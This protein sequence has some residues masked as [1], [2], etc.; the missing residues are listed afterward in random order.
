MTVL[1]PATNGRLKGRKKKPKR[2]R[3]DLRELRQ[4]LIT[5]AEKRTSTISTFF[6]LMFTINFSWSKEME[7]KYL[8]SSDAYMSNSYISK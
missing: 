8:R 7:K 3:R 6:F 4:K 1:F 5:G 2:R